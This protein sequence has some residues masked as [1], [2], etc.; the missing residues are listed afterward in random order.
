MDATGCEPAW[1]Q[2]AGKLDER[3]ASRLKPSPVN[4]IV[5]KPSC[6]FYGQAPMETL[7]A[8]LSSE[9]HGA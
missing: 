1:G 4:G 3:I 7:A 8:H 9:V 5:L 6:L 2:I